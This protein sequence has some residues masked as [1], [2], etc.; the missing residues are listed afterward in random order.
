[1]SRGCPVIVSDLP[2][3]HEVAGDAAVYV[4][5]GD[6]EAIADA[7]RSLLRDPGERERMS[8]AGLARAAEFS[9]EATAAATR[10]ALLDVVAGS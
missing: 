9:W 8:R 6:P 2:V 10:A 4:D 7:I 1:M 3:M 5:P